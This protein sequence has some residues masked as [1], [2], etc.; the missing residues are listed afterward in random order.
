[1]SETE[2]EESLGTLDWSSSEQAVVHSAFFWGGLASSVPGG[3]LT[4]RYGSRNLMALGILLNSMGA[5]AT[6]AVAVV[7][8]Q[9]LLVHG[10]AMEETDADGRLA[11]PVRA[12]L[13]HGLCGWPDGIGSRRAAGQVSLCIV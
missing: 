12:S 6:P 7:S 5:M 4:D 9:K 10:H 8:D 13:C 2:A 3:W 1:M 11:S